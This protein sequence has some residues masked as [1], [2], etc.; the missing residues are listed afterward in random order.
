M[1]KLTK[2][3]SISKIKVTIDI[4]LVRGIFRILIYSN[5]GGYL[6]LCQTYCK[7]VLE[8]K[9]QVIMAFAGRSFLDYFQI[10]G[11]VLNDPMYLWMLV[12]FHSYFRFCI[13]HIWIYLII[14][15]EHTHA[16]S[17]LW[18]MLAYLEPW[19]V[20]STNSYT[21]Y[22]VYSLYHIKHFHK[23]SILDVSHLF[24]IDTI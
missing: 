5:V 1:T 12:I 22:K 2:K 6:D 9:F 23:R 4:F 8:K 17:E 11:K 13:K 20:L 21:D 7:V 15:Q 18:V 14:I 16:Y 24:L 10:F 3:G 19:N